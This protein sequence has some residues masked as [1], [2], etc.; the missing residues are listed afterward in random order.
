MAR[1]AQELLEAHNLHTKHGRDK[2]L[3]VERDE[4]SVLVS[5]G[6]ELRRNYTALG[7]K[8]FRLVIFKGKEF[9]NESFPIDNQ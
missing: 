8:Q 5:V 7:G 1:T 9:I 6:G 2:R 3:H 4:I